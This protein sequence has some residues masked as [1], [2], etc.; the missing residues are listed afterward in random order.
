MGRM[1]ISRLPIAL[2][3][4]LAATG[5]GAAPIPTGGWRSPPPSPHHGGKPGFHGGFPIF[6][7]EREP[8]VIIEREVIREVPVEAPAPAAPPPAPREPYKIGATY[9]SLP[10]GGCLK[11][12]EGGAAYFYCGGEWYRQVGRGQYKAVARP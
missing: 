10:G 5:A 8:A 9:A 12:I 2:F 1:R 4:V 7:I 3:A 11:M 6:V